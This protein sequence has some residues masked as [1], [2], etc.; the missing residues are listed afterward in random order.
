MMP[1]VFALLVEFENVRRVKPASQPLRGNERDDAIHK[2]QTLARLQHAL[3]N[4]LEVIH[5]VEPEE[6][7][8][9]LGQVAQHHGVPDDGRL[10]TVLEAF[11]DRLNASFDEGADRDLLLVGEEVHV[12]DRNVAAVDSDIFHVLADLPA[13]DLFLGHPPLVIVGGEV[14]V[15]DNFNLSEGGQDGLLRAQGRRGDEGI[16]HETEF[17][18]L[19]TKGLREQTATESQRTQLVFDGTVG[20][21][22]RVAA[23]KDLD[24]GDPVKKDFPSPTRL[25]FFFALHSANIGRTQIFEHDTSLQ[26]NLSIN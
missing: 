13:A 10:L 7:Q 20:G 5:R 22:H 18:Q 25:I 8:H 9:L 19:I 4:D 26:I 21:R 15:G 16:R 14:G 23:H 2:E 24:T 12:S 17:L 11:K 6:F 3:L 1:N